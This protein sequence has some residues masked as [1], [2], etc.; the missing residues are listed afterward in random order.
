MYTMFK[1]GEIQNGGMAKRMKSR[2]KNPCNT[3][4]SV[5]YGRISFVSATGWEIPI[6]TKLINSTKPDMGADVRSN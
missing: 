5:T 1:F 3:E 4:K 2:D 6:E